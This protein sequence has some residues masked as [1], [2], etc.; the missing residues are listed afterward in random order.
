MD[1]Q[2]RPSEVLETSFKL[3]PLIVKRFMWTEGPRQKPFSLSHSQPSLHVIG[4][5]I[6][7][8]VTAHWTFAWAFALWTN[9]TLWI[10]VSHSSLRTIFIGDPWL[11]II[12][13]LLHRKRTQKLRFCLARNTFKN[14][15][16]GERS[17][18]EKARGKKKFPKAKISKKRPR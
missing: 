5:K 11:F 2:K 1:T 6:N 16:H 14:S 4:W 7:M 8:G 17:R 13:N 3:C 15:S 10:L 9:V 12:F 18:S